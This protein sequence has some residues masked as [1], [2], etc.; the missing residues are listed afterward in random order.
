MLVIKYNGKGIC[1]DVNLLKGKIK[2]TI[3]SAMKILAIICGILGVLL[4]VGTARESDS[5]VI[6]MSQIIIK[7]AIGL[8]LC[9]VSYALC[10]IKNALQ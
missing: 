4:V 10:F 3:L 9:L 1:I 2:K 6:T 8:G 5:S 7:T